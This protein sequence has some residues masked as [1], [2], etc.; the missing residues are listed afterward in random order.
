VG[1]SSENKSDYLSQ[2]DTLIVCIYVVLV[3]YKNRKNQAP[4]AH[5]SNPSYSRG[6]NEVNHSLKPAWANSSGD[7]TSK[8]PKTKK[9]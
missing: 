4:V 7:P 8:I 2:T 5:I 9:D 6:S 1:L 3:E